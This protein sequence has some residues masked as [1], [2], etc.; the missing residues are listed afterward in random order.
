MKNSTEKKN[1]HRAFQLLSTNQYWYQY[2]YHR[3][4]ETFLLL[5]MDSTF[6]SIGYFVHF[7]SIAAGVVQYWYYFAQC[8]NFVVQ[9]WHSTVPK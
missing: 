1:N 8:G 3:H 6:Y 2:W 9:H 7:S 4:L 5:L